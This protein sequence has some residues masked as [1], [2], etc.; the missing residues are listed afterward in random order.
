MKLGLFALLLMLLIVFLSV[1]TRK[2]MKVMLLG[3]FIASIVLY[4]FKF[5]SGWTDTL[6]TSFTDTSWTLLLMLL[7]GSFIAILK[8]VGGHLNIKKYLVKI[9]TSERKTLLTTFA[10]GLLIFVDDYLNVMVIGSSLRNTYDEQEIPRESLAYLLDVTAVPVCVLL[11]FSAWSAFYMALF[12][13]QEGVAEL[14]MTA[15][16]TYMHAVPF[17]FYPIIALII[18]LLFCLGVIPKIGP[19]KKAYNRVK[20]E[21]KLVNDKVE[22]TLTYDDKPKGKLL[23]F[24]LP[25]GTIIALALTVGDMLVATIGALLV[26]VLLY[27]PRKLISSDQ[28][29]KTVYE[30]ILDMLP[31]TILFLVTYMFKELCV[32]LGVVDY[33]IEIASPFLTANILPAVAFTIIAFLTFC[34]GMD[35]WA[36]GPLTAPI[37]FPL[38]VITGCNPLLVMA[39]IVSGAALG[40]HAYF[41]S[42]TTL[43]SAKAAG[44]S[45]PDHALSQLPYIIIAFIL[46]LVAFIVTGFII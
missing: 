32:G 44:I 16:Q 25:V 7:L 10:L 29:I 3:T 24:L 20:K 6:V 40:S 31:L 46:S 35:C 23:D 8:Y 22:D 33:V 18:M 14:G 9:A 37:A 17:M 5:I 41:Y 27:I 15:M 21:H 42:D 36:V 45:G 39:A 34:T 12:F 43:L 13:E 4:K 38:A 11:P 1:K 28:F 30:G 2:S 26:C 19:M